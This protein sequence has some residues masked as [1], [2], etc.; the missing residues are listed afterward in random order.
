M[1]KRT[2]DWVNDW[3]GSPDFD[4]CWLRLTTCFLPYA[5]HAGLDVM[6]CGLGFYLGYNWGV[7]PQGREH[8]DG[9]P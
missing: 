4:I 7:E 1:T 2:F 9:T 8:L 6:F 3:R 5:K